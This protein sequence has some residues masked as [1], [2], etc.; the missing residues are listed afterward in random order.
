MHR[1]LHLRLDR[2]TFGDLS[3]QVDNTD[4]FQN[5]GRPCPCDDALN[6]ENVP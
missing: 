3:G 4:V 1:R 6:H 2:V 5:F